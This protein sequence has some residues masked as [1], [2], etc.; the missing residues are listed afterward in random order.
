MGWVADALKEL[1]AGRQ[2]QVRPFGG[3]MARPHRERPTRHSCSGRSRAIRAGDVVLVR[4]KGSFLLHLVQ[5]ING[6][7]LL[8]GN[9]LGKTNGWASADDVRGVV[10]AV[11][12]E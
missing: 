8:I 5:E 9:N 6:D 11:T 12:P 1:A 7:R 4:W 3:S 10:V 2:V